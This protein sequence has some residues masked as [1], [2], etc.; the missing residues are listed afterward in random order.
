MGRQICN[1]EGSGYLDCQCD[2]PGPVAGASAGSGAQASAGSGGTGGGTTGAA[3]DTT[4]EGG[5]GSGEDGGNGGV[6]SDERG[7]ACPTEPMI[8]NCS[9]SCDQQQLCQVMRCNGGALA[10]RVDIPAFDDGDIVVVRTPAKP[11]DQDCDACDVGD[12]SVANIT[13]QSSTFAAVLMYQVEPPWYLVPV[14]TA[15]QDPTLCRGVQC[16]TRTATL[17]VGVATTDPEAAA[18]NVRISVAPIQGCPE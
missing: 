12:S 10:E 6:G 17:A 1:S 2:A 9:D 14:D 5:S 3:G 16:L 11:G 13:L 15:T 8:A 7:D 4:A 18:R